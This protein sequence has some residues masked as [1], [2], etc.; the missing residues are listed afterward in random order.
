MSTEDCTISRPSISTFTLAQHEALEL[1]LSRSSS[2]PLTE[3]AP[4]DDV[5]N[6]AFDAALRAPDHGQL[7]PWRFVIVRGVARDALGE[8]FAQAAKARDPEANAER[9]RA[10]AHTAPIIIAL[11]VHLVSG[12]KVPE[13]EQMMAVAAGA[14]NLLNAL[15][16]LGY[17]GF[18]ASGA[19]TYD[20]HVRHALGFALTDRLVGFLYVGTPK[21][22]IRP[23]PRPPRVDHVREWHGAA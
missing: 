4:T 17:G 5:L 18:W 14:M 2:R 23:T 15:H 12:H 6:L 7:R 8:V 21:A 19:N 10:K 9:F 16:I 13:I 20:A 3:P 11:G 22:P 1:L